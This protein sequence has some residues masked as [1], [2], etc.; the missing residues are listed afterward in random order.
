MNTYTKLITIALVILSVSLLFSVRVQAQ[1]EFLENGQ[2]GAGVA[3]GRFDTGYRR[4]IHSVGFSF[5]LT[6]ND[7]IDANVS[8]FDSYGSRTAISLSVQLL[9][10][11]HNFA[12]QPAVFVATTSD[13]EDVSYGLGVSSRMPMGKVA[14]F[15]PSISLGL[16]QAGSGLQG[17]TTSSI[18]GGLSLGVAF[19]FSSAS[20][21]ILTP[22]F[23]FSGRN[24]V[25]NVYGLSIGLL[26]HSKGHVRHEKQSAPDDYYPDD[27]D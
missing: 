12:P 25:S 21:L 20:Y 16:T 3:V 4:R 2:T 15:A 22:Q 26:F 6:L 19:H 14:L 18:S 7:V 17:S 11:A 23:S 8:V 13:N 5:G 27:F 1:S 10:N 9:P 24:S